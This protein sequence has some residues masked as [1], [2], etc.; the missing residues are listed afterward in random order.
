MG[1]Y[2]YDDQGFRVRRS[3]RVE[4]DGQTR[5]VE[6][7]YPSMYFGVEV[8]RDLRGNVVDN[9]GFGVN[10]IYL[11]GVRIAAALPNGAARYY[12]TDQ[13]DSVKV[14]L[15]DSGIAVTRTEYLPFGETWFQEGDTKNA[16]KYNSQELDKETNYY[17]Y[18]ARH[19][20]PEIARFVTP[21]TVID[22]EMSTQGW[23][24]FAY[25]HG[26]PIIY[27]D[28]TGHFKDKS[29]S[30]NIEKSG[31]TTEATIHGGIV[32]KGDT[33]WSIAKN[34]LSKEL[35]PNS[36]ITNKMIKEK[37]TDIKN[38]NKLDSNIIKPGQTLITGRTDLTGAKEDA[39]K[40]LHGESLAAAAAIVVAGKAATKVAVDTASVAAA[41]RAGSTMI[42]AVKE[43]TTK[44]V[45]WALSNPVKT[46]T[47]TKFIKGMI[48]PN[49]ATDPIEQSG[50]LT[51]ELVKESTRLIN[52]K[53]QE[54]NK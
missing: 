4:V 18:N 14:V 22:G 3:A 36:D 50:A 13:V 9:T 2:W 39:V 37:V 34:Q 28:P 27:R 24:R 41:T 53:I 20:D 21:D 8:Q 17:F 33:L 19:Y 49:P 54:K 15:N 29:E 47:G 23:N 5:Q 51:K 42:A 32:E 45:D 40:P 38:A 52:E 43:L 1:R 44:A 30:Y 16:P 11:N 35:D 12:L 26:N 6:L 48:D 31:V 10:N 46:F 7:L 25:C